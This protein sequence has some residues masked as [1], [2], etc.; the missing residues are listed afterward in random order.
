MFVPAPGC[1]QNKKKTDSD[2]ITHADGKIWF[3]TGAAQPAGESPAILL[4]PPVPL[5]GVSIGMN[6][7]GGCHPK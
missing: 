7:G 4:H 6:R 1:Y 5:V 2:F 3:H